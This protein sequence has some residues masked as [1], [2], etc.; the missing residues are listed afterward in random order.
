M[1]PCEWQASELAERGD[2]AGAQK[3]LQTT[4][5]EVEASAAAASGDELSAALTGELREIETRMA[6]SQASGEEV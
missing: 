3:A 6:S 5:E 4:R 1:V 2:L